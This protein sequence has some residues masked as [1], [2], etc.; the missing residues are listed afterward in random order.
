MMAQYFTE[1]C[2]T[3]SFRGEIPVEQEQVESP[4][5]AGR[6]RSDCLITVKTT[7]RSVNGKLTP[8]GFLF[9]PLG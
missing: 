4:S 7:R 9:K 3:S 5:M 2:E 6:S 8:M 1:W